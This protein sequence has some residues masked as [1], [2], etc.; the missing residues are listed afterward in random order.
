MIDSI[1][2]LVAQWLQHPEH[3]V[4]VLAA[5]LPRTNLAGP[6][7][8]APPTVAILND[9]DDE[10]AARGVMEVEDVPALVVFSDADSD[11]PV[12][13]YLIAKD[14]TVGIAFVTDD[15]VDSVASTRN[16]GY[17][18]RAAVISLSRFN[19]Q[20]TAGT[21]RQLNGISIEQILRIE[22][23]RIT[24][25]LGNRKCWGFLVAHVGAVDQ[26]SST[27]LGVPQL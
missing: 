12:K 11:R 17:L 25:T 16:C 14:V 6:D 4:N 2:R 8:D 23:Q 20:A 19:V 9:A 7:D 18:L 22:E 13:G 10:H 1:V 26:Y 24:G 5:K 15:R 21:A 3:G 27:M